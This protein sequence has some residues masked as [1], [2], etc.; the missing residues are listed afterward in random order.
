MRETFIKDKK[1]KVI[2]VHVMKKYMVTGGF[3]PLI[4]NLEARWR[5]EVNFRPRPLCPR[6]EPRYRLNRRLGGIQTVWMV[7]RRKKSPAPT[8]FE[9]RTVRAVPTVLLRN[10]YEITN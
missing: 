8:A 4:L 9:H 5:V 1:R 3:T 10:I 2:Y 7:W 6:K